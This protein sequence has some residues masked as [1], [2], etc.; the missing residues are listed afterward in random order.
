MF[1]STQVLDSLFPEMACILGCHRPGPHSTFV[2]F[3]RR[4]NV[5]A[6]PSPTGPEYTYCDLA[7]IGRE[8]Y[9]KAATA[10]TRSLMT[11]QRAE[12][13][14]AEN[15]ICWDRLRICF[16]WQIIGTVHIWNIPLLSGLASDWIINLR[17]ENSIR[18][19]YLSTESA[20]PLRL[21]NRKQW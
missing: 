2:N 9:P 18:R 14:I 4:G 15:Q 10:V 5:E 7:T 8:K 13:Q 19:V 1:S 6:S 16:G 11:L 17:L 3:P 20:S 21:H 12:T